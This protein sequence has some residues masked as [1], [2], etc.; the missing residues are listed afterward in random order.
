[1]T[2]QRLAVPPRILVTGASGFVGRKLVNRLRAEEPDACVI[3]VHGPQ[4]VDGALSLDLADVDACLA[5]V[6]KARPTVIVHLAALSSVGATFADTGGVWRS[7]FD[8]TRALVQGALALETDVRFVFASSGEVYGHQFNNGP[9]DEDAPL[10]PTSPYARTK[11]ACEYLLNDL[12]SERM[13]I[14]VL[15]LFNH[16]GPGQEERFVVPGFA[17]QVA[18][19]EQGGRGGQI[20]VGNLDAS[21][22]FSDVEDIIDAYLAVIR[23]KR[24]LPRLSVFNVGSGENRSVRSILDA[25]IGLA[26]VPIDPVPDPLRM[27][28]SD[29]A[30]ARGVFERFRAE[31]GCSPA[32]PFDQTIANVLQDQRARLIDANKSRQH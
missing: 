22:D 3:P 21:R 9:C 29:V 11:A 17:A 30:V 7:N 18:G 31:F 25:L 2:S 14:V 5:M 28:P 6:Q 19:L 10:A 8:G 13:S 1:V 26:T 4:N 15:R 20:K 12:A 27:R 23:H 24:P 32:R 16:S